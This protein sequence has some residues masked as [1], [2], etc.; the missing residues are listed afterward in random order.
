[1][2]TPSIRRRNFKRLVHEVW[3]GER[4]IVA[5][6][7]EFAEPSL[8]TRYMS[9]ERSK[10]NIG[11]TLAR[12]IEVAARAMGA[13]WVTDGWMDVPHEDTPPRKGATPTTLEARVAALPPAFRQY[14]LMELEVCEEVQHLAPADFLK[15]PT[16]QTRQAFQKYLHDILLHFRGK[17]TS[18]A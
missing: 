14:V 2:D 15:P 11:L 17:R 13:T 4:G 16:R 9:D 10:K 18:A 1:M 5:R 12:K 8:V 3:G 6:D 7:L